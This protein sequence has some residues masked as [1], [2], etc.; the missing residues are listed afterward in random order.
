MLAQVLYCFGAA[1]L[2]MA[3]S[4]NVTSSLLETVDV[5]CALWLTAAAVYGSWVLARQDD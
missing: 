1:W 4:L 2:L 3:N 5:V